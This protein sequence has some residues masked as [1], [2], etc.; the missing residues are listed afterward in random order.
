MFLA[1]TENFLLFSRGVKEAEFAA[2]LCI[3]ELQEPL[4][5]NVTP[6]QMVSLVLLGK[7]YSSSVSPE[8]E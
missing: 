5:Q 7:A 1:H 2:E 4:Q 8:C 3:T 6:P